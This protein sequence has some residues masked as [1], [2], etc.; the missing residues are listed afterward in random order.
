M[1]RGCL[2]SEPRPDRNTVPFRDQPVA[3]GEADPSGENSGG[4]S[5]QALS[6]QA[7]HP[8]QVHQPHLATLGPVGWL[9]TKT[10][11]P[12][13]PSPPPHMTAAWG[14]MCE[15]PNALGSLW[16][17]SLTLYPCWQGRRVLRAPPDGV[18]TPSALSPKPRNLQADS[19]MW[20]W[21][22]S[23]LSGWGR[24]GAGNS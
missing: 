20:L 19:N 2:T 14:R 12:P 7:T 9:T 15:Q 21:A 23:R 1:L 11:S 17:Q 18:V 16:K 10:N 3:E 22:S 13:S 4:D 8:L 24:K 5:A 6:M